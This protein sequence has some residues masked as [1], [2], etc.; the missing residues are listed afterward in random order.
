[1][2][3]LYTSGLRAVKEARE[4][5]GGGAILQDFRGSG[6]SKE[7]RLLRMGVSILEFN[8]WDMNLK[9]ILTL[10]TAGWGRGSDDEG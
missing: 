10:H 3:I 2:G 1:M 9:L 6:T 5:R 8:V 7:P 4:G